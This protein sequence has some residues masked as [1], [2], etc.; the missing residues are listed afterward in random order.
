MG[1]H[2]HNTIN[3]ADKY[4]FDGAGQRRV[5]I[6]MVIGLVMFA[7]G[8]ILMA[9]GVG[10]HD[11]HAT[12]HGTE[13]VAEHGSTAHDAPAA[14]EHKADAH[15]AP[16]HGAEAGH[17]DAAHAEGGHAEG[18][19]AE[20]GPTWVTVMFA[21]LWFNSVFFF[22][23]ALCGVFFV[24]INYAAFAGWSAGLIRVPMAF[25]S[26]LP[27]GGAIILAVF[28][29][30]HREIFHWT[31]PTL[32]EKDSPNFD[33]IS[34]GKS[35]FLNLPFYLG[36][37]V[38]FIGIWFALWL[39]IRGL[40]LKEDI[41][42]GSR[43]VKFH[44]K[45]IYLSAFFIVTFAVGTS[46]V[47]WDWSM[48]IDHHWYSTM[49]GWYHFAS[50]WVSALSTIALTIILLKEK[51]HLKHVNEN[52][53][54][55]LGKFMFGFSIFWTYLWFSQFML[56]FYANI[57][58]EVVYFYNRTDAWDQHY[59]FGFYFTLIPNFV[60]PLLFLMTRA[61]KRSYLLLKIAAFGILG[62]HYL[63]F[64]H[65]VMPG[66]AKNLGGFGFTEFG[67]VTFFA[68]LFIFVISKSLESAP[69]VAKNHPMLEES[70]HHDI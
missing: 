29:L 8:V 2:S 37:M 26:Y 28:L 24:A 41:E 48:S 59:R 64:Y 39:L 49:Y 22:G 56:I 46:M 14:T 61:S 54:H 31:D 43:E 23:I 17:G 19:H 11:E 18:G 60:F 25:G 36:R 62:G 67:A 20:H 4:T 63:D 42:G 3:L 57:P 55:D 47:A 40:S 9:S 34:V 65:M 1:A 16:A 66:T 10:M 38:G 15:A 68:C 5:I 13:A 21:N 7:L 53:I 52:H 30:G 58:E 6:G 69:L 12:G 45:I 44:N 35:A 51:G 27:I 50:W 32:Y 70:L 33:P